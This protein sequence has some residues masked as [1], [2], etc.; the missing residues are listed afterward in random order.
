VIDT[1]NQNLQGYLLF[2]RKYSSQNIL[3]FIPASKGDV[4]SGGEGA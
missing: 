1:P 3:D 2:L 4:L